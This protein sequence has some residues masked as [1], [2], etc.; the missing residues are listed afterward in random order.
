M[1]NIHH[2]NKK[3][4]AHAVTRRIHCEKENDSQKYTRRLYK[5]KIVLE[6]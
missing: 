5:K 6:K 3:Y 4:G 1:G 2:T